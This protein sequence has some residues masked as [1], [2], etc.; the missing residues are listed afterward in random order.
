[1]FQLFFKK[2][3]IQATEWDK[4]YHSIESIVQNSP[5]QLTRVEAYN[6]YQPTLDKD[7][8]EP[9]QNVY[10]TNLLSSW[11]FQKILRF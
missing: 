1:M 2:S 7:H 6:G 5:L 4:A 3:A 9:R 11:L 10:T 8:F